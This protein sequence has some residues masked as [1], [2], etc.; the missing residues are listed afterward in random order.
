MATLAT[1]QLKYLRYVP[2]QNWKRLCPENRFQLISKELLKWEVVD[3]WVSSYNF[4]IM[5]VQ[6]AFDKWRLLKGSFKK[7]WPPLCFISNP[8]MLLALVSP[9]DSF[10]SILN[11][12][13]CFLWYYFWR[14]NPSLFSKSLYLVWNSYWW[15]VL[16]WFSDVLYL[17]WVASS[18]DLLEWDHSGCF[19]FWYLQNWLICAYPKTQILKGLTFLIF[20]HKEVTRYTWNGPHLSRSLFLTYLHLKT[21][22]LCKY[23]V[24]LQFSKPTEFKH[25]RAACSDRIL[26]IWLLG[27][28]KKSIFKLMLL[29][30]R[31][32]HK[33]YLSVLI[34]THPDQTEDY[35]Y[36]C[37]QPH[38]LI[39]MFII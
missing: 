7:Q 36:C 25:I 26:K 16:Q 2:R 34:D 28:G 14:S 32:K 13:G 20:L 10:C 37:K 11:L 27:C 38:K 4:H 35:P 8:F 5:E 23:S 24:L 33:W 22:F 18:K 17:L 15:A 21:S 9:S 31:W 3:E 19:L 39:K 1:I 6:N 12:N 30:F 29:I